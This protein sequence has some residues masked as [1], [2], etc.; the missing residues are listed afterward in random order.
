MPVYKDDKAGTWYV[1]C[2]Y[3][4]WK[5]ET[6]QKKKRGF[7]KQS[8]AKAWERDFLA[9][10]AAG[11]NIAFSMLTELYLEDKKAHTKQITYETKKNRIEKWILPYFSNKPVDGI[12]ATD[13]RQ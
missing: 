11:P 5:G 10:Q 3:K 9:K 13:V 8:E 2:Y 7:Q 1:K 12:S 6:H 4:N